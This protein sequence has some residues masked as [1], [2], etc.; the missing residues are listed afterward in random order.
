M[1]TVVNTETSAA[2]NSTSSMSALADHARTPPREALA[3]ESAPH[4]RSGGHGG[5]VNASRFYRNKNPPGGRSASGRIGLQT[6]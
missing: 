3:S 1:P 5:H 4:R 6:S 2:R